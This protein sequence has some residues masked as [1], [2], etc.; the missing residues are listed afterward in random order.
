[1]LLISYWILGRIII[2]FKTWFCCC[3]L[4][5]TALVKLINQSV[6]V[7][8]PRAGLFCKL[9]ILHSSLFSAF[10]FVSAYSPFFMML[11]IMWYLLLPRTFFPFTIPSRASF[12]RQLLLSQWPSQFL[13]LFFISSSII[14]PCPTLFS[15][16]AFFILSLHPSPHLK[17]FQSFCSFR[18]SAQVS[19][20]YNDTLHTKHFSSLFSCYFSKGPVKS[21]FCLSYPLLYFLTAVH[22]VT[23]ITPQVLEAVHLFVGFIFT[24]HVYLLLFSSYNYHLCLIYISVNSM[25]N[26]TRDNKR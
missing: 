15:T 23:D 26:L 8:C 5:I 6:T 13:F 10:L 16:T 17:C 9:S 21:F 1:M 25:Y 18:H 14:F 24:S 3:I 19:A 4:Y 7:F 12:S 22:I 11:S 2:D 20:P